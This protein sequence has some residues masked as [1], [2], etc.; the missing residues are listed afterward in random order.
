MNLGISHVAAG[1]IDTKRRETLKRM[2]SEWFRWV[3][4]VLDDHRS[5]FLLREATPAELEQHK[6]VLKEAI[7]TSR[8]VNALPDINQ[9]GLY[10]E[11]RVR[12][13]QLQ[14]AYDVL[15]DTELSE[16]QTEQILKQAF[17]E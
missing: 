10:A 1:D 7:Q 13:Q 11:L 14:D 16:E 4:L 6:V 9:R 12:T 8:L 3:D 5:R 2:V 17:P 15:Y